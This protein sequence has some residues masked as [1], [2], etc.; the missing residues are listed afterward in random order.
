MG[1]LKYYSP[2]VSQ[3]IKIKLK[4][5]NKEKLLGSANEKLKI[6]NSYDLYNI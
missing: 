1:A 6:F 3:S 4:L 2:Y 5:E